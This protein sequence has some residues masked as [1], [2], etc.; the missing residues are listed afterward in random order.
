MRAYDWGESS[1]IEKPVTFDKLVE[2]VVALGRY[3]F[4]IVKLPSHDG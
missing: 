1:C 2:V 3:G 4:E